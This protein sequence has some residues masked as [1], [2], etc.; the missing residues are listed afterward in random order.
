MLHNAPDAIDMYHLIVL[1]AA[2]AFVV[3]AFPIAD[4]IRSSNASFDLQLLERG[5][6]FS[7]LNQED[8]VPRFLLQLYRQRHYPARKHNRNTITAFFL[9][10]R[11]VKSTFFQ[12][13]TPA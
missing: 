6:G 13:L 11:L 8:T 9:E 12:T 4:A 3:T 5:G 1:V 10:G 2:L 7:Y